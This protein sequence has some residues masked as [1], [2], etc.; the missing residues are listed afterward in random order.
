M[1]K[2][3]TISDLN[4]I[5]ISVLRIIIIFSLIFIVNEISAQDA[6]VNPNIP[7]KRFASFEL[8]GSG[9]L[10]SFNYETSIKKFHFSDL[11]FRVGLSASPI[12]RNNGTAI[13][14]PLMVHFVYGQSKHK[15]DLGL[16]QT[17]SITTRGAFFVRMPASIGY[18]IEPDDKKYFWRFSYTPIISYL[19]D[20]QWQH[21]GGI[22][23][24]IK[25]N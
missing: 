7:K 15:L 18:R 12:D 4:P 3:I 8:A 6:Y 24:G 9:G 16:G 22:S 2:T 21:W 10:A 20:F 19:V 23:F 1:I 17:I 11:Y 5:P 14:F 25:L 13:V